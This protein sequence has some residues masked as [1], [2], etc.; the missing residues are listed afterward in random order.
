MSF[1]PAL[2]WLIAI[3]LPLTVALKLAA[4]AGGND[5]LEDDVITFLTRQGF[6]AVAAEETNFRSIL[7]VNSSCRMRVMVTSNDGGLRDMVRS[8]V[9]DDDSLIFVHQG[10]VYQEQPVLLTL[11]AALWTRAFRK[12]GLTDRHE[13]VLAVVA[14]R[15]CDASRLPWHQ[16]QLGVGTGNAKHL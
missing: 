7:A 11:S 1:S 8:L 14:Q 12:M 13:A 10:E 2:K 16:L 6:Q 15:R 4:N 3:L 9:T 5:H